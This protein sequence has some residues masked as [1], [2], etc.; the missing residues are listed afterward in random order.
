MKQAK[1]YNPLALA[2]VGDAVY[3][4][5]VR[6]HL[7]EDEPGTVACLHS[8]AVSY[9]QAKR[10]SEI[11][12]QVA[13]LLNA[14]EHAI[15]RRGRNAKGG[16]QP[17]NVPAAAYRRATGVEALIGYWHLSGAE[18]KLD[19]FFALLFAGQA[20]EQPAASAATAPA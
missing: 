2:Y 14:E 1:E 17:D 19:R 7:L 20:A 9:V 8:K 18:D 4:L 12:A 3:E 15:L 16:R 13:P 11:Y 6:Q 5:R 10:Q